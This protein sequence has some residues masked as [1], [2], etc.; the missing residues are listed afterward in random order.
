MLTI[1]LNP[2]NRYSEYRH[3]KTGF[4]LLAGILSAFTGTAWSADVVITVDSGTLASNATNDSSINSTTVQS[5]TATK[6]GVLTS[7]GVVQSDSGFT[8]TYDCTLNVYSGGGLGGT[9]LHSQ[10]VGQ[11]PNSANSATD[12]TFADITLNA[13]VNITSGNVYTYE[14]S[15][16]YCGVF[17]YYYNNAAPDT[18]L[19]ADGAL[20]VNGSITTA[21]YLF[22]VVQG[23]T[24]SSATAS[25][26]LTA[27]SSVTEPVGLDTTADTSG[28]AVNLMDFTLVDD[29][30]DGSTMEI[31]QIV[32][33]VSGTSS[34]SERSKVTWRLNGNDASNVSGSYNS[35][36]DTITFSGLSIS[37]A[38]GGSETYTINGYYN[39]NTG[40][41]EDH[42][43]ILSID[44]DTDITSSGGTTMAATTPV[45]NSSGS[46]VDVTATAL[47]FTTQPAGSTSGSALTTQPVLTAQDAFGNTDVDFSEAISITEASAGSLSGTTT[48]SA[49]S[50]VATFTDLA[51]TATADQQSFTLTA[52]DE[53]G[54]GS[55]LSTTDA[56][57]VTSDVVATQLVFSTEPDPTTVAS[58]I[59]TAFT[60]VPVIQAV[61]SNATLDTGYSTT[62]TLAEVNGAGSVTMT[63]T[64][65][66][67]GSGATVSLSPT[68]GTATF[69]A[70]TLTY[71]AS[72]SSNETFN[73][74][75]SSG[76]LSSATST[77]LTATNYPVVTDANISISGSSGTYKIGDTLTASWDNSAS[78]D[79][80]SGITAVTVDFSAFGGS[81]AVAA[82]NSADTWSASYTITAGSIDATNLN[83]AV[84]ATNSSGSGTTA[85]TTNASLDNIAPLVTDAN[86][87][88][89]GASGN[90]GT[91]IAGDTVT[92]SWND[93]AAGDNNSDTISSVSADFSDFGGGSAVA[94]SNSSDTWSA[95]YTL[96]ADSVDS[97]GLNVSITAVD[98]AGNSTTTADSNG[99]TADTFPPSG[100]SVSFDDSVI[101]AS[102]ATAVDFTFA[103]G[104]AGAS[105]SYSISSSGGGTAVT[106]SGTLST[107]ADQISGL[108]VSGLGDDTLTLSVIVTDAAG[109]AAT[110]VTDTATLDTSAPAGHSVSFDDSVIDASEASTISFTFAAGEAG[111]SYS[112]SI[113]SSAGGTAVT[114]SGTLSTA[115]DQI[116]GLDVSNLNDG[117]LTLSV[118]LT[119]SAG[120]QATAITDTATL[121]QAAPSLSSSSP[122]DNAINVVYDADIVLTFSETVIA[123][124]GNFSIYNAAGDSLVETIS[125]GS[126]QIAI[127]GSQVTISSSSDWDPGAGYYVLAD[128]G[129]LTDNNGNSWT[130]LSTSTDLNFTVFDNSTIG[131]SDSVSTEEDTSVLIDVLA[132]DEGTGLQLDAASVSISQAPAHGSA[133]VNTISGTIT[134]TPQADFNGSD[135]F[136]Y[137]VEDISYGTS[138]EIPVSLTVNAI[139]DAPLAL[140]DVVSTATDTAIDADVTA[141]D[142]DPDSG[143]NPDSSTVTI[144]T[145]P[146]HGSASV[147]SGMIRYT[148]DDSFT[149]ADS[150][151]YQVDDSHGFTSNVAKLLINTG[152]VNTPPAATADT[153]VTDEDT[154][155]VIDVLSNDSDSDGVIDITSVAVLTAPL[156]GDTSVDSSNGDITYTPDADHHGSDSFSYIVRDDSGAVSAPATVTLTINSVNDAPASSPDSAAM[157]GYSAISINVL[158]NDQDVDDSLQSATLSLVDLP[159]NG[160]AVVS[161]NM[162]RYMLTGSAD[163]D[164]LTYQLEDVHGDLSAVT[165]VT[166]T[167]DFGNTAPL[168]NNDSARTAEDTTLN[169]DVAANDSDID[170]SL[171]LSSIETGTPPLYGSL[172][173][174]SDGTLTYA[175]AANYY[176]SDSF[177]YRI[178][179]NGA[180]LSD[181]ATVSISISAVN[182]APDIS[183]TPDSSLLEGQAFSFTPSA[184]DVENS[185]LTFSLSGQPDW[186][187]VD[188]T[189]GEVSGSPVQGDAGSYSGILLSVSDGSDSTSLTAF[190][191]TVEADFDGDGLADAI[192]PDDDGDEMSDEF[193]TTWGFD[194]Y[195]DSDADLDA[196]GDHVSNAQEAADNTDPTDAA[197]YLDITPPVITPPADIVL[198]ASSL[199][200]PVTLAQ[201]LGVDDSA[202]SAAALAALTSDN[203]DGAS[204][205]DTAVSGITDGVLH[206]RPGLHA[207]TYTATDKKGNEGTAS[208]T[209]RIRPLVSFSR[210][211]TTVEGAS[212]T[213]KVILNGLAPDYPLQV[214]YVI[215]DSSTAGSTDH[216][217]T[218][219]SVTFAAGEVSAS[220]S[221]SLTADGI[222]EGEEQLIVALND[223]TSNSDDLSGGYDPSNPDIYDINAG[224]HDELMIRILDA[225][226]NIAPQISMSLQQAATDTVLLTAD[227]GT[228]TVSVNVQDPNPGDSHSYDWSGTD[229][230]LSDTDGNLADGTLT[231]NPAGL[232]A[233]RYQVRVTVTDSAGATGNG[234]IY[235]RVAD[236]LPSLDAG[237]DSDNDGI[238]D[239]SEG[240][241]DSDSDGVP[242][243][244]DGYNE[245][246]LLPEV[247][248]QTAGYLTECDPDL[249]CR[250][251]WFSSAG[252]TGGVR[253][254]DSDVQDLNNITADSRFDPVG[255]IFDFEVFDL[256]QSGA[257]ARIVLPLTDPI[258]E[259][260][261]YRKFAAGSWSDFVADSNNSV[262]SSAG[263]AGY[264][265]TPDDSSWSSGLTA[266]HYCIRLT[267]EDGGPNDSDGE[268]NRVI[269]DPGAVSVLAAG[270]NAALD[271]VVIR[272]ERRGG[273]SAGWFIAALA[274]L[275]FRQ[276]R[277]SFHVRGWPLAVLLLSLTLSPVT[278]VS[279]D[280]SEQGAYLIAGLYQGNSSISQSELEQDMATDGLDVSFSQYDTTRMVKELGLG[281]RYLSWGAA[282]FSYLD[283]GR[284]EAELTST[285][286]ATEVRPALKDYYPVG[287]SGWMLAQRFTLPLSERAGLSASAGYLWW[288]G[289][290]DTARDGLDVNFGGGLAPVAGLAAD[291]RFSPRIRAGVQLRRIFFDQQQMDLSGIKM[292]V[293][294]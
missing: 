98:N 218:A 6:T 145:H 168:A 185:R 69:T 282:E 270:D 230:V 290:I 246:N 129:S 279:A 14:F 156:H 260:A 221:F 197:D 271:N 176:G 63:G 67:D 195:D 147:V 179:D 149:G 233:G 78:G 139:N 3:K 142:S 232:S 250:L 82:T 42:T 229:S 90:S 162:I 289:K 259:D 136:S 263:S 245:A 200:T 12:Y 285:D 79:N 122:A 292:D 143:D 171:S 113:S 35:S 92:V 284:A 165:T 223:N 254:L 181:W 194:P 106:G 120:N 173:D 118:V 257:V 9:L 224:A 161:G 190:T 261:V 215:S 71:T 225:G 159:A 116:S 164:S 275:A 144:V 169:I 93:S 258:P 134:Y 236:S 29:G 167:A 256:P 193:E 273:A 13:T 243:Y 219:G 244:L 121:D 36:S 188:A 277:R 184:S 192:D 66:T 201:L 28:E 133:Q 274:L 46:T 242:D 33:N 8:P 262:H 214:P 207:V 81:S 57:S 87:S 85:D 34:D 196:D 72:G 265:P 97:S 251:G 205:C 287:G 216:D 158:G 141:N 294:F 76:G 155:V 175:P 77:Q 272:S 140:S 293:M 62:I 102:E 38:D 248:G 234:R 128:S 99:A 119:D 180:T 96:T 241:A 276:R 199:F 10:Y 53:D 83:V 281:Y 52:N 109:N 1:F 227:G 21:D 51:Y 4:L 264:C 238:D 198:D 45:T 74:Q 23:D 182:D 60:T 228:A 107:A 239:V 217:L 172:T 235:F 43:F 268:R 138:A 291:Y 209:V 137:T 252:S 130:G 288:Q 151:T 88:L 47:V 70:L 65:D 187:S 125:T 206:L 204:C 37:V 31:S 191:L 56:S 203:I 237:N 54:V 2:T 84:T 94:A 20:Y 103:A 123:G 50:G 226:T 186:M 255:G 249:Y 220:V 115:A 25:G 73:L 111:A 189:T 59:S 266:G 104:E 22:R 16:S 95:S 91:F 177:T 26:N 110:A 170:G 15:P 247:A 75:A 208:Q 212:V 5:F 39:D 153:A 105:Y 27:G 80:N 100:H 108:D 286:S 131:Q 278:H 231:F 40:L 154:A 132:N 210:D 101:N 240:F 163:N 283:L 174:N 48:V 11:V 112:Y 19:Y 148:P 267:L 280:T 58:G 32:V 157:E 18:D 126:A 127:S 64:G 44:G 41:S 253:L 114:G 49:V 178:S 61:D 222:S 124:S 183:G 86:I 269:A 7:V 55:D 213:L 160:S 24:P 150:L 17:Y 89:S 117:T 202:D 30:S 146:L 211:I 135:S 68:S 166:I 152:S